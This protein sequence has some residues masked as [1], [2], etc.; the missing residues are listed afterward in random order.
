MNVLLH[1]KILVKQISGATLWV[2]FLLACKACLLIS[3]FI[4]WFITCKF[5][6][7]SNANYHICETRRGIGYYLNGLINFLRS[8]NDYFVYMKQVHTL[9]GSIWGWD[10][11]V[12]RLNAVEETSW[13]QKNIMKDMWWQ[14]YLN[15]VEEISWIQKKLKDLWWHEY[16]PHNDHNGL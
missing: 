6:G 9:V 13:I 15:A 10:G 8:S 16:Q 3:T 4:A 1:Q 7:W 12:G 5:V 2:K 11:Q 14:E